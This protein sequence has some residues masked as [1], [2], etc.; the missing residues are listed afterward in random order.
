MTYSSHIPL[1]G[2]C[3]W[4]NTLFSLSQSCKTIRDYL[5]F[6]IW[7]STTHMFLIIP[8][9]QKFFNWSV[10]VANTYARMC[11][12]Y[13]RHRQAS[14]HLPPS[15]SRR[16]RWNL[17]TSKVCSPDRMS[18]CIH[19]QSYSRKCC[20]HRSHLGIRRYLQNNGRLCI[21]CN[22]ST[23]CERVI[24]LRVSKWDF[25]SENK[26]ITYIVI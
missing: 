9:L 3:L 19:Q 22:D 4:I 17:Y 15:Q 7:S 10:S 5:T 16:N 21:W 1:T 14:L 12:L 11:G 18:S 6:F 20:I 2:T 13:G 26:F 23:E 25:R 24:H 8:T